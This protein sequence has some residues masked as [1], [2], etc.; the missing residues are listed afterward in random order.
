MRRLKLTLQKTAA[1][2]KNSN[3]EINKISFKKVKIFVFWESDRMS[4][5]IEF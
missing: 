3:M 2:K 1:E 5:V 4:E